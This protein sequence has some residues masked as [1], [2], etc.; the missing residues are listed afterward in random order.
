LPWPDVARAYLPSAEGTRILVDTRNLPD[1]ASW[2]LPGGLTDLGPTATLS[3]IG[4][5]ALSDPTIVQTAVRTLQ[6]YGL[7]TWWATPDRL[8]AELPRPQ[9]ARAQQALHRALIG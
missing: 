6:D 8:I 5:A 9:L 1:P 2:A 4:R 3:I 7:M